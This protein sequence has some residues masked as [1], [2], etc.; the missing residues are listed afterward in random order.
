MRI[1][2]RAILRVGTYPTNQRRGMGYHS[3]KIGN[4]AG[5]R[6]IFLTPKESGRRLSPPNGVTIIEKSFHTTPR[7]KAGGF[8]SNVTFLLTRIVSILLFS[9][10][11]LVLLHRHRCEI[12]HIHSPMFML[13]A[14]YAKLLR[15]RAYITFHGTDFYRI[16]NSKVYSYFGRRLDGAFAISPTMI[17]KLKSIHGNQRVWQVSN[18]IDRDIYVNKNERRRRSILAVGSL[19]DEKGFDFLIEAFK[20]FNRSRPQNSSYILNIAG[21]GPRRSELQETIHKSRL[22][23]RI[24]LLGHCDL[25]QLVSLYNESE[26]FV[27]SSVTEGF[28]KVLLEAASCGCKVVATDVGSVAQIFQDY[29]L[30]CEPRNIEALSDALTMSIST[31]HNALLEAYQ[32][33]LAKFTWESVSATYF[34]VYGDLK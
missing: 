25:H 29:P 6:T 22:T 32:S 10:W 30:V 12:I 18:G 11:G 26:V 14:L 3:Y 19:K 24:N 2:E 28:P 5:Y 17:E 1:N 8:I 4:H 15:K 13:I 34:G 33:I 7:P 27:L 31:D 20:V 16:E 23:N 9:V 21:E